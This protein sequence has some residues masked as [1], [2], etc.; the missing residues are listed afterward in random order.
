MTIDIC[1]NQLMYLNNQYDD[2]IT[3][4]VD[5]S[6]ASAND[7]TNLIYQGNINSFTRIREWQK[8]ESEV[9]PLFVQDIF[10]F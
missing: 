6:N 2:G 9:L 3:R 5:I 7:G 10:K 8:N 1:I 4:W